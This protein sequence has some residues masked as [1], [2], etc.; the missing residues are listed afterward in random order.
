LTATTAKWK[1]IAT[2]SLFV[3]ACFATNAHCQTRSWS[4]DPYRILVWVEFS[5]SCQ[6]DPAFETSFRQRLSLD[7]HADASAVWNTEI[8]PSAV[9]LQAWMSARGAQGDFAELLQSQ[10]IPTDQFD[11]IVLLQVSRPGIWQIEFKEWD[12]RTRQWGY[13]HSTQTMFSTLLPSEAKRLIE[14]K[15]APIAQIDEIR[16]TNLVLIPKGIE[17]AREDLASRQR[18]YA[19]LL[20]AKMSL[21]QSDEPSQIGPMPGILDAGSALIPVLRRNTRNGKL[22]DGGIRVVPWTLIHL[23]DQHGNAS[24]YS[25]FGQP[26]P[27]KKNVRTERLALAVKPSKSQ[28]KIKVVDKDNPSRPL[29]GYEIYAIDDLKNRANVLVG[30]TDASGELLIDSNQD[31]G[32]RL[33]YIRSG[34]VLLARLPVI[35]GREA[36]LTA[37]VL[38]DAPRLLAEGFVVGWRDK[39]IDMIARRKLLISRIERKL[40]QGDVESA[41]QWLEVLKASQNMRELAFELRTVKGTFLDAP[42]MGTKLKQRIDDVFQSGQKL[43]EIDESVSEE[44]RLSQMILKAQEP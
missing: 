9:P 21:G 5:P 23:E 36:F 14:S 26:L 4:L 6:S 37:K 38:D 19:N 3:W 25:G 10:E 11:R 43:I 30:A 39:V 40:D 20:D 27:G 41:S 31:R 28:T 8:A 17:L 12:T 42:D 34:G 24:I 2:A 7:I 16:S 13:L 15:F 32:I 35:P 1:R 18:R 22:S 33:L 44:T 29:V